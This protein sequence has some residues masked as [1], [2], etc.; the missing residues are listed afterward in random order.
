M[1]LPIHAALKIQAQLDQNMRK[2]S[3]QFDLSYVT[4]TW[5]PSRSSKLLQTPLLKIQHYIVPE[6]LR[7]FQNGTY[8]SSAITSM[9]Q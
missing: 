9:P 7:L 8:L 6:K 4:V 2:Y 1:I 3:F 5:K